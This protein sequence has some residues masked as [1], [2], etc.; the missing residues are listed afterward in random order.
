MRI[1]CSLSLLVAVLTF[2]ACNKTNTTSPP[3]GKPTSASV[4]LNGTA[5]PTN[6]VAA[7]PDVLVQH[8]IQQLSSKDPAERARAAVELGRLRATIAIPSL[9]KILGDYSA[10]E[11]RNGSPYPKPTS[12]GEEAAKALAEIGDP[13]AIGLLISAMKKSDGYLQGAMVEALSSFNDPRGEDAIRSVLERQAAQDDLSVPIDECAIAVGKTKDRK[14]VPSLA[15]LLNEARMEDASGDVL[16]SL[17][18]SLISITGDKS[19]REKAVKVFPDG[20]R[21][22]WVQDLMDSGDLPPLGLSTSK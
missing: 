17:A 3:S 9:A 18:W 6:A 21:T 11:W 16:G 5:A 12:P 8:Y 13:Q 14:A 19:W 1:Q 20:T 22:D 15:K 7:Q 2:S 4:A 10:L